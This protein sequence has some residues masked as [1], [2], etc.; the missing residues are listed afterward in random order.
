MVGEEYDKVQ[1]WGELLA[2]TMG[3]L[4]ILDDRIYFWS[5]TRV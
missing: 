5:L 4:V 1:V 2:D 3:Y